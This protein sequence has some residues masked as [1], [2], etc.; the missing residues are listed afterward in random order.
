MRN[1]SL[2]FAGGAE[3]AVHTFCDACNQIP[4]CG[5]EAHVREGRVVWVEGW[6]DH[7]NNPPCAKAYASLQEHCGPRRIL[8]PLARTSGKGSGDPGWR[9]VPWDEALDMVARRLLEIRDRYGPDSVLFYAG[10]PKEVRLP[11]MRLATAFGS[12]NYA[13]EDSLCYKLHVLASLLTFGVIVPAYTSIRGARSLL[14]WGANPAASK[15]YMMARLLGLRARGTRFVVV[16]P[17]RTPTADKLADVHLRPMPGTD[18]ALALGMMNVMFEEGLYD[19][20]FAGRWVHGLEELRG[21]A[22][23]FTPERVEELTGVPAEDLV[24]ATRLYAGN[25]PG[26][27][28]LGIAAPQ[29]SVNGTQSYRAILL[30]AALAGNLDA[31]GGLVIPTDPLLPYTTA[32]DEVLG[33]EDFLSADF[34]LLGRRLGMRGRRAD[35]DRAPVWAEL[36]P[37]EIQANFLPEYVE[38]GRIRAAI[39]FGLNA[40]AWPDRERYREA[41]GK[42]EFSVAVDHTYRPLTHDLVDVLLPAA[43]TYEREEPFY[44]SGGRVY[45]RQRAVEPRGEARPDWEIVFELALRLGLGDQFWGGDARR[46]AEWILGWAGTWR[47]GVHGGARPIAAGAGII[48][49]GPR[50]EVHRKYERGLLRR[51]GRPG[52]PTPTG[53]VEAWSTVLERH[54]FDPLPVYRGP[55]FGPTGDYPLVLMT[56]LRDPLYT[57]GRH[58]ESS[59]VRDLRP[60]PTVDVNPA[61]AEPR[62]IGEGDEVLVVTPR[63]SVVARAHLTYTMRRGVVGMYPGWTDVPNADVNAV[64]PRVLDPISGYPDYSYVCDV[65]RARR[66]EGV[67]RRLGQVRGLPCLRAGVQGLEPRTRGG[68]VGARPGAELQVGGA[69][70][71]GALSVHAGEGGAA[72]RPGGAGAAVREGVPHEGPRVRRGG[73]SLLAAGPA[74]GGGPRQAPP[75]GPGNAGGLRGGED[76]GGP[77]DA[78]S[79]VPAAQGIPPDRGPKRFNAERERIARG[80][81]IASRS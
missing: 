54:G 32:G 33:P 53:K 64:L 45:L 37:T 62:G 34:V 26:S 46:A 1:K 63:G 36:I 55:A 29:Q 60:G 27:V 61:D 6:R 19:R 70:R 80:R 40:A 47:S 31:P 67:P 68:R 77:G 20:E 44:W 79:G 4:F 10:N 39:F 73:R 59:W 28:Y 72:V 74:R 38:E 57:T 49:F 13:T 7:P 65:R 81:W 41:I 78:R 15:P 35:L 52:F 43:T 71:V 56:A 48:D 21:Y 22:S 76:P 17:R 51:D 2:N 25:R 42:L 58:K 23:R 24:R 14:V 50:E 8:R 30:L 3:R 66:V 9:A 12:A 16:D 69:L 18:G 11:L 75:Q 5:L